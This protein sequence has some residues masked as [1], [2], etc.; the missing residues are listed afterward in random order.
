MALLGHSHPDGVEIFDRNELINI[1][2]LDR[3]SVGG[4][5][6]DTAK[7]DFL[8]GHYLRDL[9]DAS[10]IAEVHRC[11]D[12]RLPDLIEIARQRMT[13]GGDA[14][15]VLDSIFRREV[16]PHADDLAGKWGKEAA[17]TGLKKVLQAMKKAMKRRDFSWT[18]DSIE[19]FLKS[20]AEA[21]DYKI[22][23]LFLTVRIATTGRKDSPPLGPVLAELGPLA[24]MQRLEA[25]TV[26]L[27]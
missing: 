9:D 21:N 26:K 22:R 7:L 16:T 8:Q 17:Q 23:D 19:P 13:F 25:A 3:L 27:R 24:V 14:T 1:F 15:W 10:L 11:L 5:V 18:E 20:V 4:P 2:D 6:F 12:E